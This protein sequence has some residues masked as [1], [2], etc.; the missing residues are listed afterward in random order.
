MGPL[1][2]PLAQLS[3]RGV[4]VFHPGVALT[5][6][7]LCTFPLGGDVMRPGQ[8]LLFS[9]LECGWY[10]IPP[11]Q[12]WL[13]NEQAPSSLGAADNLSQHSTPLQRALQDACTSSPMQRCMRQVWWLH[14]SAVLACVCVHVR[15]LMKVAGFMQ[16]RDRVE[17][18]LHANKNSPWTCMYQMQQL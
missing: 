10:P 8:E 4:I 12:I 3:G 16:P 6:P 1:S 18:W 2:P 7:R 15:R 9:H 11:Y 14:L 17:P 5:A 13:L